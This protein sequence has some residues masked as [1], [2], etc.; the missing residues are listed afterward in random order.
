[1]KKTIYTAGKMSGLTW[2]ES[3]KWRINA[4]NAMPNFNVY[5]PPFTEIGPE[6]KEIWS[7]DY[8]MLDHSDIVLANFCYDGDSP[9][10][11]TSMEIARAFYQRKPII[12]FTDKDWVEKNITLKFHATKIVKT[13]EE[14]LEYIETY[15]K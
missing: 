12:V 6:G 13:L 8:Y 4:K 5:V 11:G 9:F 2:D 3:M 1:M 14:A 7:C 15:Y 10:I